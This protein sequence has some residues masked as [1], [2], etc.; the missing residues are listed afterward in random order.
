MKMERLILAAVIGA[1]LTAPVVRAGDHEGQAGHHEEGE[2]GEA[3][4]MPDS[5]MGLWHEI[6]EHQ[7]EL[8]DIVKEGK[9]ADVHKV[10]FKVR[11]MVN[12]LPK[13]SDEL[14]STNSIAKLT[15]WVAGVASSAE[16]LDEMG[17]AG[18][19]AGTENEVKRFDTML[20]SI[21]KLFPAHVTEMVMYTCPMHPDVM[22]DE[23]GS[24]PECGMAL[25]KHEEHESKDE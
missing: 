14:V 10:A 2:E 24:C 6:N 1:I 21:A 18:D 19:Q 8:H 5:L 11:D 7:E 13:H 12:E 4:E 15:K 25:V 17:D 3:G 20:S 9:L 23:P 22:K 16:K